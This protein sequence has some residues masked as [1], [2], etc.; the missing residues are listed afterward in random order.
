M[1]S[2]AV[3]LHSLKSD[4]AVISP[5]GF[6]YATSHFFHL[7]LPPLFLWFMNEFALTF[8]QVGM[9][10]TAFFGVSGIGQAFAGIVADRFG[11]HRVLCM[12]TG[13]QCGRSTH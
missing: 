12:G 2:A 10:M 8:V 1:S 4:A 13:L 7:V 11:A 9:L 3:M 6:A 5:V